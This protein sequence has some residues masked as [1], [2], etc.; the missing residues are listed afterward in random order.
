MLRWTESRGCGS[1]TLGENWS[2]EEV[3]DCRTSGQVPS[4]SGMGWR[5]WQNTGFKEARKGCPSFGRV[6]LGRGRGSAKLT[7][8]DS[9]AGG[10][11]SNCG[12]LRTRSILGEL[13]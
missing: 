8:E 3:G 9:R 1:L 7:G 4:K 11:S 2:W 13:N 6:V 12:L 10:K 5:G